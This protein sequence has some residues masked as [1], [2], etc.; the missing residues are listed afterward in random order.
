MSNKKRTYGLG[1]WGL[2]LGYYL[3]YTP[4]SGLTKALSNG[5][6]PGIGAVPGVVLLPASVMATAAGLFGFITVAK[7]W[8]YAGRRE[9][10]GVS[11]PCPQR[12]TFLSGICMATIMGT[13]T[14][15]FTFGG[16]SIVLVLVL[17]RGGILIIAPAVDAISRRRVRWFSWA[18]MLIS[19]LAV[20]VVLG[21]A[22][23]YKLSGAAIADV[24][25]YLAAYFFKLQFMTKLSK[26]DERS[27][28]RRY[29][30]EEQMVATPLLLLALGAMAAIGAGDVMLGFRLG[31]TT[32]LES[33][34]AGLALLVGLCY[35]GLCICTTFIFLDCREN[36]FC[37][38]MHCGSS[39]LSGVTAA[40]VLTLF[41]NQPVPSAAQLVSAGLL[42][43]ALVFLSPLHHPE[44]YL[45]K[46]SGLLTAVRVGRR[47][48]R[49]EHLRTLIL[50]VCSGNTCR[51]PMAEAIAH[52]EL[53]ARPPRRPGS[54]GGAPLRASSAGL[55]VR[56]GA[57]MTTEAREALLNLGLQAGPHLARPLT[58][59]LAA[60]AER[61]FCMTKQHRTAVIAM[62]PSATQKT[63]CLDP[64]GDIEDPIGHGR[65]VYA[66]C[67]LRLQSLIRLRLAEFGLC[68]DLQ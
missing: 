20:L 64:D 63:Q 52:A 65:E 13:T 40:F 8:K 30:V 49:A 47:P 60:Q 34:A 43:V 2:G 9:F 39:M 14:L 61:I 23:N 12:L 35:A 33:G 56:P 59:E 50:F 25:A 21:D 15:A 44:R 29:F 32:F 1:I 58:A 4:Y 18:A 28:A 22:A 26:S 46:L 42:I 36:T 17:L 51:S 10:F 55:T 6:L 57:P 7:W 66:A 11:V 68:A 16:A 48:E 67:A 3:F 53:A 38:P 19:L 54:F 62:I 24:A 27:A 37:V 5:L 41:F 31:F 45:G